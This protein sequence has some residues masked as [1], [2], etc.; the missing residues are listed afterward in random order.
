MIRLWLAFSLFT[1]CLCTYAK[2]KP[3]IGEKHAITWGIHNPVTLVLQK[4]KIENY[5]VWTLS[6]GPASRV[7]PDRI[8]KIYKD[9]MQALSKH[10]RYRPEGPCPSIWVYQSSLAP[11][12]KRYACP[13]TAPAEFKK[14]MDELE[15][16]A[17]ILLRLE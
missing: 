7:L 5:K 8:A 13:E 17:R 15:N 9:Q 16:D 2:S 1:C 12:A 4:Q 11:S 10:A 3:Y 14:K 6:M